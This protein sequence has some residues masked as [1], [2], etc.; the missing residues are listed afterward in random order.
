MS[1]FF[2]IELDTTAPSIEIS[3]PAYT[4]REN[5][6]EIIIQSNEML[7]TKQEFYFVDSTGNSKPITFWQEDTQFLG[8]IRFNDFQNGIATLVAVVWDE[9]G[10]PSA[11]AE[12]SINILGNS[13]AGTVDFQLQ[14]RSVDM[15][16]TERNRVL[17]S[18]ARIGE[19]QTGT[20]N[21]HLRTRTRTGGIVIE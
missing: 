1:D 10:N 13:L 5:W 18:S 12:K 11:V 7:D 14:E 2:T 17:S 3:M 16:F 9:V 20:R 21:F 15:E 8:E 19:I 4:G 6:N